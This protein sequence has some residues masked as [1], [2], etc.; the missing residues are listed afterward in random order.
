MND[1]QYVEAARVFAELMLR[2]GGANADDRIRYAFERA[3]GRVPAPDELRE[4]AGVLRDLRADFRK[5]PEG[6][7]ALATI[8]EAPST[9]KADPVELAAYTMLG[10]LIL[11]LDEVINKH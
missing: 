9:A 6:A 11:N 7:K 1:P 4:L 5:D 10:N 8:G 2:D 3:T